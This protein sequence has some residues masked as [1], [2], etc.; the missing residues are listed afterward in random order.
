MLKDSVT[1]LI[2]KLAPI[3]DDQGEWKSPQ[4]AIKWRMHWFSSNFPPVN[5]DYTKSLTNMA[6]LTSDLAFSGLCCLRTSRFDGLF[7]DG[8]HS[9]TS[10]STGCMFSRSP[11]PNQTAYV[12][13]N[14]VLGAYRVRR[15]YQRYGAAAYFDENGDLTGIYTCCDN[16]YIAKPNWKTCDDRC[17][18]NDE[19]AEWRH[20]MWVWRVSALAIATVADHLANVHMVDAN[21]LVTASR[22]KLSINHP[23]R[24][25]LKIFTFRTIAINSK[26]YK[27][28]VGRLG[29]VNRNWAFETDDLQDLIRD[30]KI[31]FKKK[32]T[33]NISKDMEKAPNYPV[34]EDLPRFYRIVRK[35]VDGFVRIVYDGPKTT[36]CIDDA[37]CSKGQNRGSDSCIQRNIDNDDEFQTFLWAVADG[38]ALDKRQELT[39]FDDIV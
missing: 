4:E 2:L 28:L 23:M 13:D 29:V 27:T 24:A 37:G 15:G 14:T 33:D 5:V 30:T 31:G 1:G 36:T 22:S 17:L 10:S 39:K 19:Y 21:T 32:F 25:F 26:A 20:A 34:N 38:L 3:S 9:V 8:T 12:N 6:K 11:H 18:D 35:F 7:C 16:R